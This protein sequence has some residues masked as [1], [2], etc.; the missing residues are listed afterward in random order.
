MLR[1]AVFALLVAVAT[2]AKIAVI[3]YPG[4]TSH[5]FVLL[6]VAR[7][8][9]QRGHEV[10]Y[11]PA[12]VED[13]S[14]LNTTGIAVH[15][16]SMRR[17]RA[18]FLQLVKDIGKMNPVAGTSELVN[19][20]VETCDDL[21]ASEHLEKIR[22][23]DLLLMDTTNFCGLSVRDKLKIPYRVDVAP[24]SFYDP[25]FMDWHGVTVDTVHS[26][27][28]GSHLGARMNFVERLK[29]SAVWLV[30]TII[31]HVMFVPKYDASRAKH[32]LTTGSIESYRTVNMLLWSSNWASDYARDLPPHVRLVGPLLPQEPKPLPDDLAEIYRS[33]AAR[34]H[35]VIVASLGTISHI[36]TDMADKLGG[37]F[38]QLKSI[39]IW[40][41][42]DLP[43]VVP[44]NV[45]IRDWIPQNDLLGQPETVAFFSHGGMNGLQEAMYHGV[46]VIAMP[47]F[48]DQFDNAARVVHLD[49]GVVVDK[50][51]LTADSLAAEIK[52]VVSEPRFRDNARRTSR[53]IKDFDKPP[54]VEAADCVEYVLRNNGADFLKPRGY[55]LNWFQRNNL[56]V[57]ATYLAILVGLVLLFRHVCCCCCGGAPAPSTKAKK[58]KKTN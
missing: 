15:Q 6:S 11:L 43:R 44:K 46:P 39:V 54:P 50:D 14:H 38:S 2:A 23:A 36:D 29:N 4:T 25:F 47:G 48:A 7:E 49:T 22:D 8:L 55:L 9:A 12:G 16:Y 34:K 27:V 45:V 5:Q 51:S 21:M 18:E 19:F 26:P 3:A 31:E 24:V 32:G 13:L 35:G 1:V 17:P 33:E 53:S 41:T 56:D 10:V 40:K 37:A 58:T 20:A 52:G 42:T 57:R 30:N 28:L